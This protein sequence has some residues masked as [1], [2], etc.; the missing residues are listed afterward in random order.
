MLLRI[1][2]AMLRTAAARRFMALAFS[3]SPT[4]SGFFRAYCSPSASS[5]ADTTPTICSVSGLSTLLLL[6]FQKKAVDERLQHVMVGEAPGVPQ[7][8][9]DGL[10]DRQET[11]VPR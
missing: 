11:R 3:T 2:S 6:R 9:L 8:P 7:P 5:M 10:E 1:A 4:S